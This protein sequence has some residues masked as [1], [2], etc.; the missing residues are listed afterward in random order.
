M[1]EKAY[2]HVGADLYLFALVP[3]FGPV[4]SLPKPGGR[5]R[6]H[7]SNHHHATELDLNQIRQVIVWSNLNHHYIREVAAA[8]AL[9]GAPERE[10]DI[11]SV[12]YTVNRLASLKLDRRAHPLA[13]DSIPGLARQGIIAASRRFDL[14]RR[15]RFLMMAWFVMAALSP[16]ALTRRLVTQA[17]Y[18][19]QRGTRNLF[20][21]RD[22]TG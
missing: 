22:A 15:T 12:T 1:P 17:F 21:R 7:P 4:H 16:T 14:P 19:E 9:P 11:L 5:Y 18:P 2:G 10:S 13:G 8:L 20:K 3:L 6:V